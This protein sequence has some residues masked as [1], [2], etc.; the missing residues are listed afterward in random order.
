MF[1][2]HT[3]EGH[4]QQHERLDAQA[5][6]ELEQASPSTP[7]TDHGRVHLVGVDRASVLDPEWSSV[8]LTQH[9]ELHHRDGSISVQRASRDGHGDG[10]DA[11]HEAGSPRC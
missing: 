6:A 9:D 3:R 5:P 10:V 4:L 7:S 1:E 8:D 11:T 2:V